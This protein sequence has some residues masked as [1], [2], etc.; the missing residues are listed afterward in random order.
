M[1]EAGVIF[2]RQVEDVDGADGAGEEGLGAE[3]G[4]VHGRGRRGEVEDEVDGAGVEGE[5]DVV[6]V[7]GEAR[8]AGEVG[9]VG[10]VAGGEVVD[11]EDGVGGGLGDEGVCEVRAEKACGPGDE[12]FSSFVG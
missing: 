4:V 8:L 3:A 1:Q 2:A 5:G 10:E 9:E 12:D 6:I 7:E 11:A